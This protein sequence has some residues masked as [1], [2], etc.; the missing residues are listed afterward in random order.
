VKSQRAL[1]AVICVAVI[2]IATIGIVAPAL[3][4]HLPLVQQELDLQRAA[5]RAAGAVDY[6]FNFRRFCFCST[7]YRQPGLVHVRGGRIDWVEH[8]DTGAALDADL[9]LTVEDIF[10]EAQQALDDNTPVHQEIEVTMEYD[11]VLS[12]PT[13]LYIDFSPR[14]ADEEKHYQSSEM[15][16][17]PRRP[18]DLTG[19]GFVDFQDLTVLL[20]NWNQRVGVESG[21]L[22]RPIETP[23]NFADLTVL[24]SEWTGPG[25]AGSPQAALGGAAVPEPSSLVLAVIG[26]LGVCFRR[27]R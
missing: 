17:L 6:D 20:A 9:Y 3:A 18:S 26:L 16:I 8:P 12:F 10:D 27:R 14:I 22:V 15:K 7:D 2:G 21:N 4:G 5:W 19:N 24:L 1:S 11:A 13:L 25:P 23:V